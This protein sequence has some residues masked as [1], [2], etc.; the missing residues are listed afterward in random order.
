MIRLLAIAPPGPVRLITQDPAPAW[1]LPAWIVP[2]MLVGAGF[3][4][5]AVWAARRHAARV[6]RDPLEFAFR[7]LCA[8]LKYSPAES[9]LLREASEASGVSP[10]A[11]I[12]SD[13]AFS[14]GVRAWLRT[15]PTTR[16]VLLMDSLCERRGMTPTGVVKG[17]KTRA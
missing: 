4:A 14:V 12:V 6:E 7:R 3:A 16:A 8:K 10:M 15:K 9:T 17:G 1:Q 13:Q 2:A 5:F 11:I